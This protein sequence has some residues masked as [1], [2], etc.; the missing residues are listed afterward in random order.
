MTWMFGVRRRGRMLY[1]K[2]PGRCLRADSLAAG[3]GK[4]TR[5]LEVGHDQY[6]LRQVEMFENGN[7]LRYDRSHWCDAFGQLFGL[8]F[9]RQPKWAAFFPGGGSIESAEFERVWR[10]AQRSPQWAE[11]VARSRAAEWGAVPSWLQQAEDA[12]L[13]S[14]ADGRGT[15]ASKGHSLSRH[16]RR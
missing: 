5:Y 3:W 12:E 11:Q 16:R 14:A 9:S 6:A 4:M 13:G 1:V 10:A 15:K 2:A 8:R 7:V